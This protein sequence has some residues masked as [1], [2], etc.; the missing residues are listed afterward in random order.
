MTVRRGFTPLSLAAALL[1][2]AGCSSDKTAKE[3][4]GMNTSN[5]QRVANLYAGFQNMVNAGGPKDEAEFKNFIKS[6][7][8]AKLAAMGVDP[9]N[10]EKTFTSERD[11]KPFKVRY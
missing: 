7:D 6:Y 1:A 10:L 9:A 11:N 3:I 5:I 2:V 4:A 8:P